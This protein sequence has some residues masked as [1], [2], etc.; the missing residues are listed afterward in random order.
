[1][2]ALTHSEVKLRDERIY[3]DYK[4]GLSMFLLTQKYKL[5]DVNIRYRLRKIDPNYQNNPKFANRW[6]N[7]DTKFLV[8]NYLSMSQ[9]DIA[10]ALNKTLKEIKNKAVN[11]GLIKNDTQEK[12][13][14]VKVLV[15]KDYSNKQIASKLNISVERVGQLKKMIV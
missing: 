3:K 15:K 8:D 2:R 9:K 4:S 14:K 11:L 12:L 5:S 1:M 7:Q 13:Y 6:S 10:E